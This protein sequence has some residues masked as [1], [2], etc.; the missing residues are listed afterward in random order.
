M[1]R[2]KV[3]SKSC[4]Y[5]ANVQGTCNSRGRACPPTRAPCPLAVA[6]S[7]ADNKETFPPVADIEEFRE[8][9]AQKKMC[10][11]FLSKEQ[12]AEA[13]IIFM[14]YNYVL[15]PLIRKTLSIDLTGA[16]IILDEAHNVES[17]AA[18]CGSFELTSLDFQGSIE[19]L[20]RCL[21]VYGTGT[22][23][24]PPALA[25]EAPD[26]AAN[27]PVTL[28]EVNK[29]VSQPSQIGQQSWSFASLRGIFAPPRT[30]GLESGVLNIL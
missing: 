8:W 13:D 26:L 6:N 20:T 5:H 3:S 7:F 1:C 17:V 30:P 22:V 15:D 9:G 11:Y 19:E 21:D 10:P 28:D 4:E 14:P 2:Q 24:L 16:I 18:D 23:P 25:P 12:K 29:L 27:L